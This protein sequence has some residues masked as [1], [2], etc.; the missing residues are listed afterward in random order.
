MRKEVVT[1]KLYPHQIEG[2]EL[3]KDKNRVAYYWDM[4]L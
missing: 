3:A 1:M 4:G 2:L